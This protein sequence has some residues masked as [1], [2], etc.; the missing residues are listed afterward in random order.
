MTT[1]PAGEQADAIRHAAGAGD[2]VAVAV[3][4]IAAFITGLVGRARRGRAR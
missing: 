4:F 3:A 1:D 2:A